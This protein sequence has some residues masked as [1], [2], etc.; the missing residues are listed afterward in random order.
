MKYFTFARFTPGKGNGGP[1]SSPAEGCEGVRD[2]VKLFRN[3]IQVVDL[4]SPWFRVSMLQLSRFCF[5][6]RPRRV[7]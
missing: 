2:E 7:T 4:Q 5:R 6:C 1:Y 3:L